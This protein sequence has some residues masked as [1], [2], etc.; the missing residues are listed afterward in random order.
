MCGECAISES[1]AIIE[2]LLLMTR[3]YVVIILSKI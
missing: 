3:Y 2:L 1:Y